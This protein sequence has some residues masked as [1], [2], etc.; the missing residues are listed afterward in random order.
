MPD[1]DELPHRKAELEK[2][3]T[4]VEQLELAPPGMR[5]DTFTESRPAS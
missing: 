1:S 5:Q 2:L 4:R 3:L